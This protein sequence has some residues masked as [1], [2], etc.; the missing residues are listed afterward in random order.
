MRFF[1]HVVTSAGGRE[2]N[3]DACASSVTDTIGCW[4][5]ADGLG[6]HGGGSEASHTAVDA[7]MSGF[8]AKPEVSA[9]ALKDYL[10]EASVKLVERQDK[11]VAVTG[12]RTT[13]VVLTMNQEGALWGHV[14]DSRLYYFQQGRL[15]RQT[16]DHSV[17]QALVDAGQLEPRLIRRHDDRNRLLRT[18]GGRDDVRATIEDKTQKICPGDAF[19]LTSDGFWEYVSE[20]AMELDLAK[21]AT[22]AEWLHFMELRIRVDAPLDHDNYSAVAVYL[23]P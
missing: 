12:M 6:G 16:L 10:Q 15:T 7:V 14:G 20:T 13:I 18:L 21:S 4:V 17:P 8:Q 2:D 9:N 23:E 3:Q 11:E 19:L 1:T 22:P 5:L